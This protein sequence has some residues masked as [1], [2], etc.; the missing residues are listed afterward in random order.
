MFI[1]IEDVIREK[2]VDEVTTIGQTVLLKA[3]EGFSQR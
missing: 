2:E 3:S 1:Q